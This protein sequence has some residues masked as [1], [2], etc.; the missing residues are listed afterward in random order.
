[1]LTVFWLRAQLLGLQ[2]NL[3]FLFLR[4]ATTSVD[5]LLQ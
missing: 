4:Q 3:P 5:R 2:T 1:M